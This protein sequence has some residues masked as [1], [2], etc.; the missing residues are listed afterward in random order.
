[1]HQHEAYS[2]S[3]YSTFYD[4]TLLGIEDCIVRG[5]RSHPER[6]D[7]FPQGAQNHY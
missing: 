7:I 4:K 2:F 5:L 6:K 1:M 3:L